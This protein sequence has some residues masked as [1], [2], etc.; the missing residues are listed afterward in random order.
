MTSKQEYVLWNAVSVPLLHKLLRSVNR[1]LQLVG[2]W[3]YITPKRSLNTP[4]IQK[5]KG[6]IYEDFKM[7]RIICFEVKTLTSHSHVISW[8]TWS[9]DS[10]CMISYRNAISTDTLSATDFKILSAKC[11]EV[12]TWPFKVMWRHRSRDHSTPNI[13]F[14]MGVPLALTR[15]FERF[16]RY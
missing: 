2:I 5:Y 14:P 9:F 1:G 12:T 8:V 3:A 13:W 7:L 16:L 10:H 4:K 15:Y 6:P 11:I